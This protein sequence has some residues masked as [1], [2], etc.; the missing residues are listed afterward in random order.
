MRLL[1]QVVLACVVLAALRFAVA[2]VISL[3]LLILAI[4]L[5]RHPIKT[6]TLISC[7]AFLITLYAQPLPTLMIILV[8]LLVSKFYQK[9]KKL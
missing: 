3:L 2:L 7:W 9:D 5:V 4:S 1:G 8:L 6:I